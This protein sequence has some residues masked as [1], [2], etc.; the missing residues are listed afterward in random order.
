MNDYFHK[1]KSINS[2]ENKPSNNEPSSKLHINMTGESGESKSIDE[3][4]Q[5]GSS[6]RLH[7]NMGDSPTAIPEPKPDDINEREIQPPKVD[8]EVTPVRPNDDG[9]DGNSDK[10]YVQEKPPIDKLLKEKRTLGIAIGLVAVL[11]ILVIVLALGAN[12]KGAEKAAAKQYDAVQFDDVSIMM[13][14]CPNDIYD[15]TYNMIMQRSDS[16]YVFSYLEAQGVGSGSELK[17][18]IGNSLIHDLSKAEIVSWETTYEKKI[19]KSQ[20]VDYYASYLTTVN[21]RSKLEDIVSQFYNNKTSFSVVRVDVTYYDANYF[22][23][24]SYSYY[25]VCYKKGGKWY[26]SAVPY[27]LAGALMK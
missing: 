1:P 3:S 5:A 27:G 9:S 4:A 13:D 21:D 26:S 18:T 14:S 22:T 16:D 24:K 20:I 11:A 10:E 19:N 6:S 17:E 25:D 23:N 2:N 8:T 7:V 12:K 15:T